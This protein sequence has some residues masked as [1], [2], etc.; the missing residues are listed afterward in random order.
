MPQKKMMSHK[1]KKLLQLKQK[2]LLAQD[3]HS[4]DLQKIQLMINAKN[5]TKT[6]KKQKQ[7]NKKPCN[8]CS[9]SNT[10]SNNNLKINHVESQWSYILM[11]NCWV[12]SLTRMV[13]G[14]ERG[15]Y[16]DTLKTTK[17]KKKQLNASG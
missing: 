8:V 3:C 15:I 2:S 13:K 17:W 10:I 14:L 16:E 11:V 12:K 5:I 6:K 9:P 1:Q 4:H 7:Q